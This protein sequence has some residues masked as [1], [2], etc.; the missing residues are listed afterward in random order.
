MGARSFKGGEERTERKL[1][2]NSP[3]KCVLAS[4]LGL[5]EEIRASNVWEEMDRVMLVMYRFLYFYSK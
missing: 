3:N 2:S 5:D 4:I 1:E